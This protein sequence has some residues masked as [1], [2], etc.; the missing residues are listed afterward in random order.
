MPECHI[1]G[2]E[3]AEE[4]VSTAMTVENLRAIHAGMETSV[5]NALT[6]KFFSLT[7]WIKIDLYI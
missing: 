6:T 2:R 7:F 3:V 1:C 4:D 5:M